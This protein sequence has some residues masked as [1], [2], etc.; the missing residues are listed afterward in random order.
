MD[1]KELARL[2][3]DDLFEYDLL[4]VADAA[5]IESLESDVISIIYKH[6]SCYVICSGHVV[7]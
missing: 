1:K 2:I 6:L 5:S 3:S 4:N 7:E